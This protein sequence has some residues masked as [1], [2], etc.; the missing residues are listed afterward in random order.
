VEITEIPDWEDDSTAAATAGHSTRW[1]GMMNIGMRPTVDGTRRVIEVNIF[2][3]NSDIYGK[4]L[5]I[6]VKKHL[7]GEQKFAGLDALKQQLAKD[8][9]AAEES[10]KQ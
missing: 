4:L 7:R 1:K 8:K 2:D 6:F 3:F 5:R 9:T 10:F